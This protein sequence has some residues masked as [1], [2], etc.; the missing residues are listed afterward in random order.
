MEQLCFIFLT[1]V[2]ASCN[3]TSFGIADKVL[4]RIICLVKSF[5]WSYLILKREIYFSL[6]SSPHRLMNVLD[7][8]LNSKVLGLHCS[9]LRFWQTGVQFT[10][11]PELTQGIALP[12]PAWVTWEDRVASEGKVGQWGVWFVIRQGI[13]YCCKVTGRTLKLLLSA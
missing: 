9:S 12:S 2:I 13:V 3:W 8:C 10:R 1:T 11:L 6:R 7:M 5:N 4:C